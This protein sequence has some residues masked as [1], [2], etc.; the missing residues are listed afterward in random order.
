MT[1]A[2]QNTGN[3]TCEIMRRTVELGIFLTSA[4]RPPFGNMTGPEI[5]SGRKTRM[6]SPAQG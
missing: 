4:Q 1:K 2:T 3:M 6:Q 5:V